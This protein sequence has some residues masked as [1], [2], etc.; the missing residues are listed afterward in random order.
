MDFCHLQGTLEINMVKKMKQI[1]YK[2]VI[3]HQKDVNK[4]SKL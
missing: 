2:K 4:L 3:Y 1:K